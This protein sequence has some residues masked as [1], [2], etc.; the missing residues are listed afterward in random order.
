MK[1]Q[2]RPNFHKYVVNL[3]NTLSYIS[4]NFLFSL[5]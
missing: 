3:Y 5:Y 2:H 1:V 4:Y